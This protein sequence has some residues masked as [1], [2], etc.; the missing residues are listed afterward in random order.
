MFSTMLRLGKKKT[1]LP[2]LKKEKG[3]NMSP[4]PLQKIQKSKFKKEKIY[5]MLLL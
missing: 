5:N 2:R 4:H 1:L 3:R